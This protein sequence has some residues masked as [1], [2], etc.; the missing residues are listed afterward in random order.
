[1]VVL[2]IPN[3]IDWDPH[4]P[5]LGVGVGSAALVLVLVAGRPCPHGKIRQKRKSPRKLG[6]TKNW[7]IE[8]VRYLPRID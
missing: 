4:L 1:M 8:G 3:C 7:E 6:V 5:A 2:D